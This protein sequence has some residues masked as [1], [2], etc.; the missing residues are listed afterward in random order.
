[1]PDSKLCSTTPLHTLTN[2]APTHP[3]TH[4]GTHPPTP[5][6]MH[7]PTLPMHPP[8]TPPT[9]HPH[10]PRTYPPWHPPTHPN[11][12]APTTHQP[13]LNDSPALSTTSAALG[14]T[15][16]RL[17]LL[18]R[19]VGGC[20]GHSKQQGLSASLALSLASRAVGSGCQLPWLAGGGPAP[21]RGQ[22][23]A[24]QTDASQGADL[25]LS[26]PLHPPCPHL[27]GFPLHPWPPPPPCAL[28]CTL[29]LT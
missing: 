3:C 15:R 26:P 18:V 29:P 22:R 17:A 25:A 11:T 24:P 21:C 8:P 16:A 10:Q 27:A 1:M 9:T 14:I 13:T 20:V 7:P 19:R 4:P 6:P 28:P 23:G 5:P 2:H 12:H